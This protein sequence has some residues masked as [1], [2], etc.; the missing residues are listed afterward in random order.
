MLISATEIIKNTWE[1]YKERWHD[2]MI[3]SLLIFLPAF[4]L[5][6]A[7]SFGTYINVYIPIT[8]SLT[9]LLILILTVLAALVGFWSSL[10]LL[11]A[12]GLFKEAKQMEEW[13]EHYAAVLPNLWKAI[14]TSIFVAATV[15][16]GTLLLIIPGIIFSIWF[17][18]SLYPVIFKGIAGR[19]AM[20]ESKSLVQGR[21]LGVFWRILVPNVFFAIFVFF[22]QI[23]I[24]GLFAY[25][26]LSL[27]SEMLLSN[28]VGAVLSAII[29]PLTTLA[30]V[31][32]YFDLKQNPVQVSPTPSI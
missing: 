9:N 5:T 7:G 23:V 17:Y 31:N 15:L 21:W 20:R 11:H 29:A 25:L 18:F 30:M 10:A 26:S 22:T 2:W 24:M 12:A 3:F 6:L 4:I 16:F 13:R 27:E 14:Y 1:D 28:L 19:P 8:K 32:L